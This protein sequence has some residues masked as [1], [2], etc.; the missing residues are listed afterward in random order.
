[1]NEVISKEKS[2]IYYLTYL[3]ASKE[4]IVQRIN[5]LLYQI[6]VT[7][8]KEIQK[9]LE[10]ILK[11]EINHLKIIGKIHKQNGYYPVFATTISNT[12]KYWNAYD[13]YYDQDNKSILEIDIDQKKKA[14][15]HYQLFLKQITNPT[16]K[17]TMEHFLEEEYIYLEKLYNLYQNEK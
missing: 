2:L 10:Q 1:M 6:V 11:S 12:K 4:G 9:E 14:I 8:K 17:K 15:F 7:E 3:Y 5:Q 16:I 13:L